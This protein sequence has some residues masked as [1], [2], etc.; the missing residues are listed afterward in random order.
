MRYCMRGEKAAFVYRGR[1]SDPSFDLKS[2]KV[3][4]WSRYF[5]KRMSDS[6]QTNHDGWDLKDCADYDMQ[7]DQALLKAL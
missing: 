6:L 1:E 5:G 3:P 4:W 2:V 7:I